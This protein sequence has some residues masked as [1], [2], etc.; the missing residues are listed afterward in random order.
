[1]MNDIYADKCAY[2]LPSDQHPCLFP[3]TG[4]VYAQQHG[5]NNPA[6]SCKDLRAQEF[7]NAPNK[8]KSR[9]HYSKSRSHL[10]Q[11]QFLRGSEQMLGFGKGKNR[12][13]KARS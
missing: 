4:R 10:C 2:L 9:A 7:L 13:G 8:G 6:F 12:P 11:A 5:E 3:H 1:M